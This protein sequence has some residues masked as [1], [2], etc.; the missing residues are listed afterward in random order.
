[1]IVKVLSITVRYGGVTHAPG[2]EFDMQDMHFNPNLV[3]QST[4]KEAPELPKY[5]KAADR[6]SVIK[7]KV[8]DYAFLT[9]TE[10]KKIKN[11]DLKAYL[12]KESISYPGDAIK[13]DYI[14]AILGK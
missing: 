10:L 12:D 14:N 2:Q 11:D 6:T 5:S 3:V 4:P 13:E 9:E 1:M 7:P 8:V